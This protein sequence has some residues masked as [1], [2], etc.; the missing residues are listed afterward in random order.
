MVKKA[1]YLIKIFI[2]LMRDLWPASLMSVKKNFVFFSIC[3]VNFPYCWS[4][5]FDTKDVL[6][7]RMVFFNTTALLRYFLVFQYKYLSKEIEFQ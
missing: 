7:M 1:Q 3:V 6:L 5:H 2:K 4:I